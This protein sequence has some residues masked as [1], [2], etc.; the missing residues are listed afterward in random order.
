MNVFGRHY[1]REYRIDDWHKPW[2]PLPIRLLN[3]L[4]RSIARSVFAL[5]EE[6][7]L[8]RAR[9]ETGAAF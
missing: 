8:E 3:A 9:R 4:P 5:D 7:L 2:L 1:P 6:P